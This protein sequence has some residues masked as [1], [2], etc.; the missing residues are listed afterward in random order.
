[1]Y[2]ENFSPPYR[3]IIEKQGKWARKTLLPEKFHE[4]KNGKIY[5]YDLKDNLYLELSDNSK[6]ECVT[7]IKCLMRQYI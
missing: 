1:M 5:V 3:Q 7:F 6:N 4:Y 2:K